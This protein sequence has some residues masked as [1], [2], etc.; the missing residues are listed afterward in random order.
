MVQRH[1]IPIY[2]FFSFVKSSY[3]PNSR[4]SGPKLLEDRTLRITLQT[5]DFP[6]SV[7]VLKCH[8]RRDYHQASCEQD[9][10][11]RYN[12]TSNHDTNQL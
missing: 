12:E 2:V 7:K 3:R 8:N 1:H 9:H 10:E 6:S 5:L 11:R 4:Q